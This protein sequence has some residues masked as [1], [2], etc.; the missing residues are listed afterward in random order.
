MCNSRFWPWS[1]N[2]LLWSF[3]SFWSCITQSPAWLPP[4]SQSCLSPF[5]PLTQFSQFFSLAFSAHIKSRGEYMKRLVTFQW[6]CQYSCSGGMSWVGWTLSPWHLRFCKLNCAVRAAPECL[7]P[8][9]SV[10]FSGMTVRYLLVYHIDLIFVPVILHAI[11]N[12]LMHVHPLLCK[13]SI[14]KDKI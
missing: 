8:F 13:F 10:S 14:K 5:P 9:A 12:I 2:W 1:E 11:G 7:F 6:K 4:M 3:P